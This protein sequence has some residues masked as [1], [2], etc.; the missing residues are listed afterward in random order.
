MSFDP[1]LNVKDMQGGL[2]EIVLA[3][4]EMQNG[5]LEGHGRIPIIVL[6]YGVMM[7]GVFTLSLRSLLTG[8]LKL[9]PEFLDE[10]DASVLPAPLTNRVTRLP[11]ARALQI[12]SNPQRVVAKEMYWHQD[13]NTPLNLM[14]AFLLKESMSPSH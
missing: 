12:S 7:C 13:L 6:L 9:R 4:M 8:E 11:A 2:I 14:N 3:C 10:L 1:N 5:L